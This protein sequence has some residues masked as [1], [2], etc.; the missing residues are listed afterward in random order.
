MYFSYNESRD[1]NWKITNENVAKAV[2][3][4]AKQENYSFIWIALYKQQFEYKHKL[5]NK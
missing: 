4:V 2:F 1:L 5:I 3:F